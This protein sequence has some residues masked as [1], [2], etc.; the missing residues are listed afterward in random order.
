MLQHK[1]QIKQLLRQ[2]AFRAAKVLNLSHLL[3][4]KQ[5]ARWK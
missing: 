3:E 1:C 5:A 2:A 4:V